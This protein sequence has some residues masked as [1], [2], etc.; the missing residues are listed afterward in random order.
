MHAQACRKSFPP[1]IQQ[2]SPVMLVKVMCPLTQFSVYLLRSPRPLASLFPAS[3]LRAWRA[4]RQ[5]PTSGSV[6]SDA[7]FKSGARKSVGPGQ[8]SHP[9]S[10][11]SVYDPAAAVAVLFVAMYP[12][13]FSV[14]TYWFLTIAETGCQ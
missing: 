9:V 8:R 1:A 6:C 5:K 3:A 4:A 10:S 12:L 7:L 2:K 14:G 13:N 11:V